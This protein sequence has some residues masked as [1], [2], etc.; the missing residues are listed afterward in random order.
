MTV[1]IDLP[2]ESGPIQMSLEYWSELGSCFGN[3]VEEPSI[4]AQAST[5]DELK[6]RIWD[7]YD[8]AH[9][10]ETVEDEE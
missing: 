8:Q 2:G 7:A 3:L 10:W 4:S 9:S 1:P 6:E 5:L